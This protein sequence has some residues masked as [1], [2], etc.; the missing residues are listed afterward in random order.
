MSFQELLRSHPYLQQVS[1]YY[2]KCKVHGTFR[3]LANGVVPD[4]CPR[5]SQPATLGRVRGVICATRLPVPVVQ[6][7]RADN[8]DTMA[9][10]PP[11]WLQRRGEIEDC[12]PR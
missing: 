6:R 10:T 12:G 8:H 2:L 4:R 7:W 11:A 3:L 1:F 9:S 5:C